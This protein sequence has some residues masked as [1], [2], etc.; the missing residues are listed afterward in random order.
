MVRGHGRFH[1][2][3]ITNR[4][5]TVPEEW[6]LTVFCRREKPG[7]LRSG[8]EEARPAR[9][10][11]NRDAADLIL[12]AGTA[13]DDRQKRLFLFVLERPSSRV[14][15]LCRCSLR[16]LVYPSLPVG[17]SGTLSIAVAHSADAGSRVFP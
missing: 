10:T 11:R 8:T 3:E 2:E 7:R 12:F 17:V 4:A 14:F 5:K 13:D 6:R 9:G 15:R 1:E 16:A